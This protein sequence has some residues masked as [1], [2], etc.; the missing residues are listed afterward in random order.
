MYQVK[1]QRGPKLKEEEALS[2]ATFDGVII[3][4]LIFLFEL[5]E[6]FA[7]FSTK[8]FLLVSEPCCGV[9]LG[10]FS[11]LFHEGHIYSHLFSSLHLSKMQASVASYLKKPVSDLK[12][13]DF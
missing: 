13:V 6:T 4:I 1:E 8:I 2:G 9:G 3:A 7:T 12:F 11:F 10:R 5:F